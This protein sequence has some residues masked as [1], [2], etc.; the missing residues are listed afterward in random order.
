MPSGLYR[1]RQQVGPAQVAALMIVVGFA[2]VLASQWFGW[3]AIRQDTFDAADS[4]VPTSFGM[5]DTPSFLQIPYYL[6]WLAIFSCSGAAVFAPQ[7]RRRPW[8]AAA[9]GALATQVVIVVPVLRKPSIVIDGII[10][11]FSVAVRAQHT[12]GSYCVIAALVIIAAALI[13]AVGGRVMPL[14]TDDAD[15]TAAASAWPSIPE[16]A[17]PAAPEPDAVGP[18]D[19]EAAAAEPGPA[20][21]SPPALP[22]TAAI[23]F[24][25][26][27]PRE[28]ETTDSPAPPDHSMYVRPTSTVT[29]HA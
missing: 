2:L 20:V 8:F 26:P 27:A 10:G 3:F 23:D 1:L 17:T 16:Q 19:P 25:R 24:G 13:I 6:V 21:P 5:A 11:D 28:A 22:Q 4:H 18:A 15:R 7:S 29:P 14:A 9:A 12:T